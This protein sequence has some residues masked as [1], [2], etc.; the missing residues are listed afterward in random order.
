MRAI[1]LATHDIE[2]VGMGGLVCRCVRLPHAGAVADQDAWLWECL[3]EMRE[4]SNA[5][6]SEAAARA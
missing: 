3:T 5:I 2:A 1:F 6:L 4:A